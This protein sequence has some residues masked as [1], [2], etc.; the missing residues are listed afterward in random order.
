MEKLD[1][2]NP[3]FVYY[4]DERMP[5]RLDAIKRQLSYSNIT[6]WI[7]PSDSNKIEC[8]YSGNHLNIKKI[9]SCLQH[10]MEKYPNDESVS[11][12]REEIRDILISDV[13]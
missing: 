12:F 1:L 9:E 11:R 5:S 6:F 7:V 8:V 2:N 3:I 13:L 10:I 4:T